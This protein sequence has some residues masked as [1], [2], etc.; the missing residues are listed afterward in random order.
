HYY[1]SRDTQAVAHVV[2]TIAATG[3]ATVVLTNGCG[4]LDPQLQPGTPV[5]ISDHINLTGTTALVGAEIVDMTDASSQ[6][7]RTLA[8]QADRSLTEGVCVQSAGPQ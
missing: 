3:A 7:L 4:G 6:R 1:A 8:K 5:L 2:R